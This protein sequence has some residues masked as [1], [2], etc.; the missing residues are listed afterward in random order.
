M[1]PGPLWRRRIVFVQLFIQETYTK[2]ESV[3]V[4]GSLGY[5]IIP[6]SR[7]QIG[8]LTR[9]HQRTLY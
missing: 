5:A 9:Q 2:I 6:Q 8:A 4:S 1:H 3:C 7:V